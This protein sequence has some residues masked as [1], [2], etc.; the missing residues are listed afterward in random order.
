MFL[1]CF[2]IFC[3]RFIYLF[4]VWLILVNN[5]FLFVLLFIF[6]GVHDVFVIVNLV[7]V[8]FVFVGF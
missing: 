5:C 8:C 7:C 3:F 1:L 2:L 6:D 4:C